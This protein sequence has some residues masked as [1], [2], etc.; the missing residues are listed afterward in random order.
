[1]RAGPTL[2]D[3]ASVKF[4][5]PESPTRRFRLAYGQTDAEGVAAVAILARYEHTI[6]QLALERLRA[7]AE[8]GRT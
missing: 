1:M 8:P 4:D 2:S 5:T 3:I 7:K 6:Y